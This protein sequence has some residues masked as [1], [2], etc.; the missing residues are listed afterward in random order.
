MLINGIAARGAQ[1]QVGNVQRELS[2]AYEF[3]I[4]LGQFDA[5]FANSAL[6]AKSSLRPTRIKLTDNR[7]ICVLSEAELKK[8]L[9][10]LLGSAFS[11]TI[12]NVLRLTL[13]TGCRTGDVCN[14]A[15]KDIDLEKG[16]IHLRESKTG[17]GRYV[18][19]STQ[20]I[21]FL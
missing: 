15:W 11:P 18:R 8:F 19:L 1:V 6:L 7:S 2:L 21:D 14:M 9:Q 4:G 10:W 17:V 3:A 20:A 12:K 13:W 16:T 5:S